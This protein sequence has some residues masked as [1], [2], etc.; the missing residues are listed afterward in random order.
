MA[1]CVSFQDHRGS[2]ILYLILL[3][4]AIFLKL[5]VAI[6]QMGCNPISFPVGPHSFQ[7]IIFNILDLMLLWCVTAF[8]ELLQICT[9]NGLLYICVK[10]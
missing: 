7:Y 6:H 5:W 3:S 10:Q 1:T 9:F 8:G 2:K 4:R